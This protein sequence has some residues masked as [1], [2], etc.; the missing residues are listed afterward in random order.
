MAKQQSE[1]LEILRSMHADRVEK[2]KLS[3]PHE[4]RVSIYYFLLHCS[5]L[6][7]C[8]CKWF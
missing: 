7:K 3:V 1:I 8:Y 4:I 5:I 6:S 2:Q